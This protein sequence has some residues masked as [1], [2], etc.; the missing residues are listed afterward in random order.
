MCFDHS[1][2]LS[3]LC[4][5]SGHPFDGDR[6]LAFPNFLLE[7]PLLCRIEVVDSNSGLWG[8]ATCCR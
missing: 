6:L 4:W 5:K 3:L 8:M 1:F 2:D 7:L